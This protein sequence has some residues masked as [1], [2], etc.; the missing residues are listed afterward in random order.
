MAIVEQVD[1]LSDA[2]LAEL[3]DRFEREPAG[4]I[5]QSTLCGAYRARLRREWTAASDRAPI[6]PPRK[7]ASAPQRA[8][9]ANA[10]RV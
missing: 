1:E 10:K 7:T 6:R 2:E 9:W 8:G 4:A 5:V 3:S